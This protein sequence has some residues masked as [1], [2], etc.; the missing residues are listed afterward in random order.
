MAQQRPSVLASNLLA[1]PGS[2]PKR[3]PEIE[4]LPRTVEP[5]VSA[6]SA[7]SKVEE[8]SLPLT[9]LAPA[10][11]ADVPPEPAKRAASS[12]VPPT[13]AGSGRGLKEATVGTTLYLLPDESYRLKRLALDLRL[14]LHDLILAGLDLVLEQH[15]AAPLTRYA[16]PKVKAE[17]KPS[18]RPRRRKL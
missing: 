4:D 11:I 13:A 7:Q 17:S 15:G 2:A 14:S 12:E 6:E 10:P 1:R 8:Q 18:A 16:P 3:T 5:Q 9:P